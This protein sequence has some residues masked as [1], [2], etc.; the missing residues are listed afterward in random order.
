DEAGL[1]Y[2]RTYLDLAEVVG[3]RLGELPSHIQL[4]GSHSCVFRGRRFAHIVLRER[5]SL[6]S[7]L[8]TGL[9]R[10]GNSGRNGLADEARTSIECSRY[11]GDHVACF[12]TARHAIFVVSSLAEGQNLELARLLA[13]TV[14]GHISHAEGAA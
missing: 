10:P 2:D 5:G 12:E 9:S 7:V 1:K 14:C 6:I 8:V 4:V 13:P 11:D 3:S